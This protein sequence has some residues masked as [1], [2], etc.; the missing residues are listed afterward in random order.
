MLLLIA[1]YLLYSRTV[2]IAQY[3]H[4]MNPMV[5]KSLIPPE[6][7]R[8]V[9]TNRAGSASLATVLGV[10]EEVGR[11]DDETVEDILTFWVESVA[12]GGV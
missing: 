4:I 9:P 8:M 1:M 11:D 6:E 2:Y 7:P 3:S 10:W 12:V 5:N